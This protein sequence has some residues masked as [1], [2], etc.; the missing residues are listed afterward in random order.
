[1]TTKELSVK[2]GRSTK[3]IYSLMAK[4]KIHK[5]KAGNWHWPTVCK[6]IGVIID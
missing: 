2:W 1:M 4:G 6:E 3:V 5:T